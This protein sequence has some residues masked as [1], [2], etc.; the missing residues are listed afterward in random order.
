MIAGPHPTPFNLEDPHIA[1][2]VTQFSLLQIEAHLLALREIPS[3]QA[4]D[5]RTRQPQEVAVVPTFPVALHS[6]TEIGTEIATEI[7]DLAN[8]TDHGTMTDRT[9]GEIEI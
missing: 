2:Q 3:T 6:I 8:P 5:F 4:R 7:P 9:G 1:A